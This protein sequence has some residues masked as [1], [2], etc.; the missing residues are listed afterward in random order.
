MAVEE[1]VHRDFVTPSAWPNVR[2]NLPVPRA[3]DRNAQDRDPAQPGRFDGP[4]HA[5]EYG[6]QDP[7]GLSQL[8]HRSPKA[9]RA[10]AT[11]RLDW[12]Y[13]RLVDCGP[14]LGSES[15]LELRPID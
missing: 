10:D 12:D 15:I 2:H 3:Q 1:S 4:P 5:P 13:P 9:R 8:A 14:S 11:L 6:H 7:E